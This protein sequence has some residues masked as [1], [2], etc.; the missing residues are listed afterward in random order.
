[1][2]SQITVTIVHRKYTCGS[3]AYKFQLHNKDWV[4]LLL[5][6]TMRVVQTA[7]QRLKECKLLTG[8]DHA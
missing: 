8:Q 2:K 4:C 3:C 7:A 1:M 5:G 6:G